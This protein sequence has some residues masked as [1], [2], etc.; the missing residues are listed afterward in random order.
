M[1]EGIRKE[2]P[3]QGQITDLQTDQDLTFLISSS[4][5]CTAKV[6]IKLPK[7]SLNIFHLSFLIVKHW[8]I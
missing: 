6:N 1:N 4:K 3:H 2:K 7:S 8:N 5:D